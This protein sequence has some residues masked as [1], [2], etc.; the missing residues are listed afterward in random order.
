MKKSKKPEQDYLSGL[1]HKD[2]TDKYCASISLVLEIS[3]LEFWWC[4]KHQNL[5]GDMRAIGI[6]TA[7][8]TESS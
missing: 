6:K 4:W 1:K 2:T 5:S 3:L 7:N 8:E